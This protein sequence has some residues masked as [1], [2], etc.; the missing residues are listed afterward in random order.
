MVFAGDGTTPGSFWASH[1]YNEDS[2]YFSYVHPLTP[3]CSQISAAGTTGMAAAKSM[4]APTTSSSTCLPASKASATSNTA[5]HDITSEISAAGAT[6]ISSMD[7][8][9]SHVFK[10]ALV[11][12][13]HVAGATACEWWAHTRPHC[14]G[15]QMHFDSDNE[16]NYPLSRKLSLS[17]VLPHCL[18]KQKALMAFVIQLSV[19]LFLCAVASEVRHW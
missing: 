13:P 14:N 15:H 2:S 1:N 18:T 4:M 3:L 7:E 12:F 17:Q 10:M 9:I 11:H 6:D 19:L 8:I 16:G 5:I